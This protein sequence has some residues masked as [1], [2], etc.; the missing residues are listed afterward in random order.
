M[1]GIECLQVENGFC[2]SGSYDKT[3]RC[4]NIKTGDCIGIFEGHTDGGTLFL[5]SIDQN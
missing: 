4:F 5:V 3:I 1:G 2:F